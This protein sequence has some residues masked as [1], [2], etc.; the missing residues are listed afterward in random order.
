M[1]NFSLIYDGL[2]TLIEAEIPTYSRLSDGYNLEN[3]DELRLAKGYGLGIAEG[4]NTERYITGS[5]L[6]SSRVF[7]LSL[8]RI[9]SANET[10]AVGRATVEKSLFEDTFKIWKKLQITDHLGGV[11][12]TEAKYV[13]DSGIQF[14][15]DDNTKVISMVSNISLEFF[16]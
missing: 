13:D 2:I 6:T 15:F 4:L 1:A 12:I 5:E 8:T 10:D 9:L 14:V 11:Q 3:N 16:E 7:I